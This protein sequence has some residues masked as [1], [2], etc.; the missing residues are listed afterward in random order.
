MVRCLQYSRQCHIRGAYPEPAFCALS[1]PVATAI[2]SALVAVVGGAWLGFVLGRD[3]HHDIVGSILPRCLACSNVDASERSADR[4]LG[5]MRGTRLPSR[6]V[7]SLPVE[8]GGARVVA[9]LDAR[10]VDGL[11]LTLPLGSIADPS[12]EVAEDEC[13]TSFAPARDCGHRGRRRAGRHQSRGVLSERPGPLLERFTTRNAPALDF[14][15]EERVFCRCCC[16]A[17]R[18][19]TL[20]DLWRACGGPARK[21]PGVR[22][23]FP[24][25]CRTSHPFHQARQCQ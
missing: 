10:R 9:L 2:V 4:H 21:P 14:S 18:P 25:Q 16:M 5:G 8:F 24:R 17:R 6:L 7:V 11:V 3:T 1:S 15:F 19:R 23:S 12:F 22:R 13:Y 20:P